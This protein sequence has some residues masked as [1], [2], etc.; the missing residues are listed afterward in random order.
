MEKGGKSYPPAVLDDE[1]S[2]NLHGDS[3][4]LDEVAEVVGHFEHKFCMRTTG[5]MLGDHPEGHIPP[6]Q[7]NEAPTSPAA[8]STAALQTSCFAWAA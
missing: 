6:P 5:S 7:K 2:G 4:D 3:E 8:S 1:V